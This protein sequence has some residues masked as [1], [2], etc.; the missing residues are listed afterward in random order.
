MKKLRIKP[1]Q[2][3]SVVAIVI[4]FF[5]LMNFFS[6]ISEF[7][8]LS[9]QRDQGEIEVTALNSTIRA[10]QTHIAFAT[11]PIAVEEWARDE[12]HMAKPGDVLII[13][14]APGSSTQAPVVFPVN[15][16]EPVSNWQVWW[17]LFFNQ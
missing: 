6:R 16:P 8:R 13:P 14:V 3:L 4:G 10:L 11:Q 5:L 15:T 2:L 9:N 17:A 7:S 1:K 12:A